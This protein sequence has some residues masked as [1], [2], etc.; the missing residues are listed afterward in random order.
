MA[1]LVLGPAHCTGGRADAEL[2]MGFPGEFLEVLVGS[3][4]SLGLE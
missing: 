3:R 4:F 1:Y 2:Q